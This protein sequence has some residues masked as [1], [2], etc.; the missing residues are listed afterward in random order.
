M[1]G[2]GD[3]VPVG[4]ETTIPTRARSYSSDW[5]RPTSFAIWGASAGD[6]ARLAWSIAHR[7]DSNPFWFQLETPAGIHDPNER[8]VQ[9]RFPVNH[10]FVVDPA[11][12]APQTDLGNMA[13]Y[14]VREGKTAEDRLRAIT[15]FMRLPA[16]ARQILEGRS[17]HSPTKVLAIANSDR[18][19]AFYSSREGGIVPLIDAINECAATIIFIIS[20]VPQPQN[21][22]VVDYLLRL[23]DDDPGGISVVRAECLQGAPPGV[24]GLFTSGDRLPLNAMI[25]RIDRTPF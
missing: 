4:E 23:N 9:E 20:S 21:A 11:E 3:S 8:A 7:I 10:F 25:D 16:V 19:A 5:T 17:P 1:P 14:F 24:P 13:S 6:R 22:L 2:P 12:L 15:D 18:A